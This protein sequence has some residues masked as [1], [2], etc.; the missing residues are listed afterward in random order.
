MS[1]VVP[2]RVPKELANLTNLTA[3]VLFENKDLRVPVGAPTEKDGEMFHFDQSRE[4]G[5]VPSVLE[6]NQGEMYV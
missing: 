4:S 5:D 2:G 3:L 1:R 6:I